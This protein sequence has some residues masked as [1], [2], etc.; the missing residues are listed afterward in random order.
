MLF[1]L[2]LSGVTGITSVAILAVLAGGSPQDEPTNY[3]GPIKIAKLLWQTNPHS[4]SQTLTSVLRKAVDRG[5]VEVVSQPLS[6][7]TK[8]AWAILDKGDAQDPRWVPSLAILLLT[9][10]PSESQTSRVISTLS[11]SGREDHG[12]LVEVWFQVDSQS[13][14][15]NFVQLVAQS[16]SQQQAAELISAAI[17]SDRERAAKSLIKAWS[18]LPQ[19]SK[20][21][22]IEPLSASADTMRLL[23]R[24]VGE[25]VVDRDLINAN[26]L[27]KWLQTD[28]E[29]WAKIIEPIWGK[30]RESVNVERQ[31][32]V[33]D[34]LKLLRSGVTGSATNGRAM[35][36]KV[37]S[38]CHVLHDQGFEVG[39]NIT[40]NGRGNLEQLVS[41]ILDPSLVIGEAFMAR[42]VLTYDGTVVSG[43]VVGETDRY[44][45]LKVQGG[46]TIELDKQEDIESLK[47]SDKS[48]MPEGLE[49]Q[50]TEQ[51]FLD[52][53]AFLCLLKPLQ[54]EDNSLIPGTPEDFVQP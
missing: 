45:K 41:N 36:V 11:D 21:A 29:N 7:L 33:S 37:C 17:N 1:R 50:L 31:Q 49:A 9:S 32:L 10:P 35:F 43:L 26:Q 3:G 42:T 39:P 4:A 22:A 34:K 12:I 13:A 52:L 27:R 15:E 6:E 25:K 47:L 5:Q 2:V 14:F 38:Q 51:E 54:A 30:I 28:D 46:K 18:N 8:S 19:V 24:A 48:L 20:S 40:N 23:I 53:L 44:L 16:D